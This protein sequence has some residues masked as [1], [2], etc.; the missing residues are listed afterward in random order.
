VGLKVVSM[1]IIVFWQ[2]TCV[3]GHSWVGGEGCAWPPQAAESKGWEK[4]CQNSYFK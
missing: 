1:R 4:G 3:Q 2:M